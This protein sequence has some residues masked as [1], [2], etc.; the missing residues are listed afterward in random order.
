MIKNLIY[1]HRESN[2]SLILGREAF[3]HYTMCASLCIFY[4]VLCVLLCMC[5]YNTVFKP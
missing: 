4:F 1:A 3:Y 5:V 2:P